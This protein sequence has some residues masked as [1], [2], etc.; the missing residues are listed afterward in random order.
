MVVRSLDLDVPVFS[1]QS[2]ECSELINMKKVQARQK[3]QEGPQL[4]EITPE[5]VT[6]SYHGQQPRLQAQ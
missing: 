2:Q 6:L 3:L 1:K 4:D 5:G